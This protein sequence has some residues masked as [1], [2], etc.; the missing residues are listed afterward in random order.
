MSFS[1]RASQGV[2]PGVSGP[3]LARR[4]GGEATGVSLRAPARRP[5]GVLCCPAAVHLA[6]VHIQ[7][8]LPWGCSWSGRELLYGGFP[9]QTAFAGFPMGVGE[10][11]PSFS[12]ALA[13]QSSF[14]PSLPWQGSGLHL[15]L[16]ALPAPTP[17]SLTGGGSPREG[18]V[19]PVLSQRAGLDP[20]FVQERR[21]RPARLAVPVQAMVKQR[22]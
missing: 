9:R 6:W 16:K 10:T 15:R 18:F 1:I 12:E 22:V 19:C 20:V 7:L 13:S 4:L 11:F 14:L 3:G 2:L 17:L 21:G 5:A 8:V